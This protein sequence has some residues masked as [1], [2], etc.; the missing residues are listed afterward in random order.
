MHDLG[1]DT[2]MIGVVGA[3][4][5]LDWQLDCLPPTHVR[6]I[7]LRWTEHRNAVLAA[8]LCQTPSTLALACLPKG[9]PT[10]VG[11]EAEA[12][13]PSQDTGTGVSH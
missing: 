5:S 9:L 3:Q 8:G 13:F 1:H 2:G 10:F 7:V 12:V 4:G 6:C 11:L